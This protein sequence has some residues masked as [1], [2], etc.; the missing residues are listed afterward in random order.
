MKLTEVP[1][2]EKYRCPTNPEHKTFVLGQTER[3][4]VNEH[5]VERGVHEGHGAHCTE[6]GSPARV[7]QQLNG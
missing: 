2:T 1:Q 3:K 4:V 7:R 5:G 6:C